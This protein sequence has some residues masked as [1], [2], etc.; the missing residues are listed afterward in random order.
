MKR[1]PLIILAVV[2]VLSIWFYY[3]LRC[4]LTMPV[5]SAIHRSKSVMSEN[6]FEIYVP[7]GLAT[8]ENDWFASPFV[9]NASGF[10]SD[11]HE[12][13]KMSVIY[14]FPAFDPL[15]RKNMIFDEG[16]PYHSAFYGAYALSLPDGSPY[17]FIEED[18]LSMEQ[19]M[20]VFKY[21]YTRLVLRDLGCDDP[22]WKLSGYSVETEEYI[23]YSGW[24]SIEADMATCGLSHEYSVF[25]RNYI[26]YGRP[27]TPA[28]GDYPPI[29][30]HGKLMIRYFPEFKSTVILYAC[31]TDGAVVNRCFE[32]ILSR[33]SITKTR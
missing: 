2:V 11:Y 16:S 14:V 21:D 32:K 15:T 8:F 6:G 26:Q 19:V 4:S 23:G 1:V 12:D 5:Y 13:V 33:C 30:L 18:T 29:V 3:P 10:R 27:S 7:G 24:Y 20:D 25:L 22:L 31:A 9:Y 28:N 17:G